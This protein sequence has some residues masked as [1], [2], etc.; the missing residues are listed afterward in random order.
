MTKERE[1]IRERRIDEALGESFPASDPP[2][3]V[4]AGEPRPRDGA[5]ESVRGDDHP[6]DKKADRVKKQKAPADRNAR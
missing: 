2:F 1:Q 4:G 3:F 6:G 5:S